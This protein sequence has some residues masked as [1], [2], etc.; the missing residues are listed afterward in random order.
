MFNVNKNVSE[1]V[2][3]EFLR[4]DNVNVIALE[5]VSHKDSYMNSYKLRVDSKDESRLM[6]PEF[7]PERIGCR[8]YI[9]ARLNKYGREN[10]RENEN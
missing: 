9:R 4:Q 5:C 7:W 8:K 2:I 10:G 6:E 3:K 1:D